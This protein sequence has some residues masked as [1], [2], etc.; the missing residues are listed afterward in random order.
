[1][2]VEEIREMA[3]AMTGDTTKHG[4]WY[5]SFAFTA[6]EWVVKRIEERID[7][8]G[9]DFPFQF[10]ETTIDTAVSGTGGEYVMPR[11]CSGKIL[12]V[13]GLG[14]D[15][16]TNYE[17]QGVKR[18]IFR[19][20]DRADITNRPSYTIYYNEKSDT[21]L[22]GDDR[23]HILIYWPSTFNISTFTIGYR[24]AQARIQGAQDLLIFPSNQGW[25]EIITLGAM[26]WAYRFAQENMQFDPGAEFENELEKKIAAMN[27]AVPD[28]QPRVPLSMHDQWEIMMRE[29]PY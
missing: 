11:D 22:T 8:L 9:K 15:G 27:A 12:D 23:H 7:L 17:F 16:T 6:I 18:E 29:E 14:T 26:K 25:E 21:N 13:S 3:A 1:M 2:R 20:I 4:K 28:A 19:A 5:T 24:K 10:G